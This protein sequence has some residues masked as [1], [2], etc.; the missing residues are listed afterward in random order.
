MGPRK[1]VMH[2]L[3]TWAIPVLL[4]LLPQAVKAEAL[5]PFSEA[6]LSEPSP[7]GTTRCAA[8]YQSM[9]EWLGEE[10]LGPRKWQTTN[11]ARLQLIGLSALF[12]QEVWGGPFDDAIESVIGNVNHISGL[13]LERMERNQVATG[14][15]FL[16]DELIR[17]DLVICEHVVESLN[18]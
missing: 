7:Y 15:A 4:T 8:L 18:Q 11:A 17:E 14:L 5:K 16:G 3:V 10:G 6:I 13:Y 2:T 1:V 9:M 12:R